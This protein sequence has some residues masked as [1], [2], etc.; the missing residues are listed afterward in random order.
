[1]DLWPIRCKTHYIAF[2]DISQSNSFH[3]QT[4]YVWVGKSMNCSLCSKLFFTE[5]ERELLW[6]ILQLATLLQDHIVTEC[7][8]IPQA[9]VSSLID[10]WMPESRVTVDIW[11]LEK[12][13]RIHY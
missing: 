8:D 5:R 4:H 2:E 9:N 1:M 11:W 7:M 3:N 12:I 10:I 13:C 6:V